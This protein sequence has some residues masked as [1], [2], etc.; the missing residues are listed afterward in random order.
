M[1]VL[2]LGPGCAKCGELHK[3]VLAALDD[4]GKQAV[5]RK[6]EDM[7]EI[8]SWGVMSTPSLVVD[9]QVRL[10][11]QSASVKELKKLLA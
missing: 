5:V 2:I 4:L 11:G 8:M 10:A 3:N 7:K 6:V 9:G 1:E